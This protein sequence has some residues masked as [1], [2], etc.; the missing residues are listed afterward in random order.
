[1]R[2]AKCAQ[3]VAFM[4]RGAAGSY[5]EPLKQKGKILQHT[6]HENARLQ[7]GLFQL[8]LAMSAN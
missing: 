8:S 2:A 6:Q 1:M 5:W 4:S 3:H 7:T